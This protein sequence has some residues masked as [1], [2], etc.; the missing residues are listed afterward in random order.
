VEPTLDQQ[1]KKTVL[2][3]VTY[4]L[5]AVTAAAAGDRGVFT[6]NWLTQVSFEPPL[7]GLSVEKDSSTLSLI[8]A[9]G[10]FAVCPLAADQRELAGALGR[11]RARVGDKF[12]ALDLRLREAADGLPVLADALGY[13]ACRVTGEL[14]AGDSV[15]LLAEVVEAAVFHEGDP[16]TMREAGFRHAG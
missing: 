15:L 7:L 13:V 2:R 16:L 9:S 8:R 4:G 10:R 5:Y 12:A 6:A 3:H 1:A 11:P 14:D